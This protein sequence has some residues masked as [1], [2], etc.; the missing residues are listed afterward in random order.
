MIGVKVA[1]E[2]VVD[3]SSGHLQCDRVANAAVT[4]VEEK[5]PRLCCPVAEL[6]Q[7]GRAFL[8]RIGGARASFPER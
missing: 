4:E 1:Y 8:Q 6:D 5:A 3:Q 7:H 2:D